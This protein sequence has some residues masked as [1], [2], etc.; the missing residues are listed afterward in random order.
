[1]PGGPR[2][3]TTSPPFSI[4]Y[5]RECPGESATP[6]AGGGAQG[7]CP[8]GG[9]GTGPSPQ[10]GAG[11]GGLAWGLA[12]GPVASG[13]SRGRVGSWPVQPLIQAEEQ[14]ALQVTG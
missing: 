6:A 11:L 8:P 2:W 12:W 9:L 7:Q 5:V 3:V 4:R 13:T 10:L 1:M 14:G